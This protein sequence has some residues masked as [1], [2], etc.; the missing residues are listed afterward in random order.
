[1]Q[2]ISLQSVADGLPRP[3]TRKALFLKTGPSQIR[4]SFAKL[5]N[6]LWLNMRLIRQQNGDV[7]ANRVNAMAHATFQRVLVFVVGQRLFANRAGK[8]LE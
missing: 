5:G 1:M 7:I 2:P 3:E 6:S 8:N 4:I